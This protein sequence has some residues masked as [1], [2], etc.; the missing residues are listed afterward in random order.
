MR[1]AVQRQQQVLVKYLHTSS[2][3]NP[4]LSGTAI[5]AT[6]TTVSTG[7][8]EHRILPRGH[9]GYGV[10]EQMDIHMGK[11]SHT[12]GHQTRTPYFA[13]GGSRWFRV[14]QPWPYPPVLRSCNGNCVE[15]VAACCAMDA[16]PPFGEPQRICPALRRSCS[17]LTAVEAPWAG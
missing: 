11:T 10:L 5:K 17:A 15:I 2:Y 3:V 16:S 1:K 13:Y 7:Y 4:I 8:K 14:V 9:G 6:R 12:N